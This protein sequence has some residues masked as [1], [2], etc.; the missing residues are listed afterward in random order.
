M[1]L[2]SLVYKQPGPLNCDEAPVGM[3]GQG[4]RSTKATDFATKYNL[5]E[6]VAANMYQAE[7]D[8]YVP[9]LYAKL[10]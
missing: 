6:P 10:K 9:Q 7:Y 2:H 5:G 3:T 8:D 4:R 1:P